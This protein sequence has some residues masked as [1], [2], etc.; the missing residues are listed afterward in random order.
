MKIIK[1]IIETILYKAPKNE[2]YKKDVLFIKSIYKK[3]DEDGFDIDFNTSFGIKASKSFFDLLPDDCEVEI[4]QKEI[5]N[6]DEYYC[7]K[8]FKNACF[9]QGIDNPYQLPKW[10]EIR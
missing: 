8:S 4:V 6:T 3:Y 5:E 1:A 9:N 10:T 2:P 7:E